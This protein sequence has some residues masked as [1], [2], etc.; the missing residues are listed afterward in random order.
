MSNG[1]PAYTVITGKN[2]VSNTLYGVSSGA[3]NSPYITTAYE[4][5]G[6][7]NTS[8]TLI[9]DAQTISGSGFSAYDGYAAGL[10]GGN[11]IIGGAS[12]T[13][14]LIGSAYTVTGVTPPLGYI[15]TG[16]LNA[17]MA[18]GHNTLESGANSTT[19]EYGDAYQESGLVSGGYNSLTGGTGSTNTLVGDA[20]TMSGTYGVVGG[21]NTLVRRRQFRQLS[22]RRRHHHERRFQRRLQC[23]HRRG[24]R[25]Q[26]ARGRR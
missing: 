18:V 25:L 4:L 7:S 16:P 13:N 14:L 21:H 15:G 12:S 8:N 1:S 24:R 23:P 6:G 9:G 19:T 26:C 3:L 10:A 20:N 22:L 11:L 17:E 5:V 2:N